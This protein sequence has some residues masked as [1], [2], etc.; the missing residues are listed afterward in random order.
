MPNPRE[1]ETEEEYVRRFIQSP[2]AIEDYPDIDQRIAVAHAK[3]DK[4]MG[5]K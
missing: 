3:W 4:M 2:E 1:D 5:W